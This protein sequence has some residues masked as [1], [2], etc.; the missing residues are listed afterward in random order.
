MPQA[1]LGEK[2]LGAGSPD[3][4]RGGGRGEMKGPLAPQYLLCYLQEI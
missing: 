3:R 1:E 4:A 2:A